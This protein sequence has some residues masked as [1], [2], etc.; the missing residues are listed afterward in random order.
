MV[1]HPRP[2]RRFP[3]LKYHAHEEQGLRLELDE[4]RQQVQKSET[5]PTVSERRPR[6]SLTHAGSNVANNMSF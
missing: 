2:E 4:R 1:K 3:R 6:A 5:K